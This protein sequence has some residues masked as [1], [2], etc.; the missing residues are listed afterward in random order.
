MEINH[1]PA[2]DNLSLEVLKN[3]YIPNNEPV[4]IKGIAKSWKVYN[5]WH[6]DYLNKVLGNIE[7]AHKISKTNIF[8]DIQ[9]SSNHNNHKS[10]FLDYINLI[11]KNTNSKEIKKQW[12]FLSG[13]NT[14]LFNNGNFNTKFDGILNDIEIPNFIT[15][16]ALEKIGLWVSG[17]DIK[18]IIHYDSNG[19]HNINAQLKGKKEVI[20][21][22]PTEFNNLYMRS[23]GSDLSFFNFS[24]INDFDITDQKYIKKFPKLSNIRLLKGILDEGDILFLPSFWFHA[25]HHIGK[26]NINI[27]FWW[28]PEKI[29]VNPTVMSWIIAIASAQLISHDHQMLSD[30]HKKFIKLHDNNEDN[31]IEVLSMVKKLDSI[32][33]SWPKGRPL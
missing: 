1:I 24:N 6:I 11:Q 16:S 17:E 31:G 18:S 7:I 10:S 12:Y 27:N 33:S 15:D 25:F 2:I 4:I 29:A 30:K 3:Y 22:N 14:C 9:N 23:I 21:V 8:P 5:K 26:I 32:I 28:Q 13:D 20:L 19:C